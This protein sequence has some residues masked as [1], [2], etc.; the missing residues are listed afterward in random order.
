MTDWYGGRFKRF[1]AAILVILFSPII[2][3][4]DVGIW[5]I[6]KL[7]TLIHGGKNNG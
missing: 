6:N 5:I 4:T 1:L 2:L 3:I 7:K